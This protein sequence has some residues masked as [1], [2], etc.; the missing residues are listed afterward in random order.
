MIKYHFLNKTWSMESSSPSTYSCI[1]S[2][3]FSILIKTLS[4]FLNDASSTNQSIDRSKDILKEYQENFEIY[5]KQYEMK[6]LVPY[7]PATSTGRLF[8]WPPKISQLG[9]HRRCWWRLGY[10]WRLYKFAALWTTC[11]EGKT[12]GNSGWYPRSIRYCLQN[13]GKGFRI[14]QR[15]AKKRSRQYYIW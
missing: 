12:T 1:N 10:R 9:D 8:L 7:H 4:D 5:R 3:S 15:D 11:P 2:I 13:G 14:I 6:N